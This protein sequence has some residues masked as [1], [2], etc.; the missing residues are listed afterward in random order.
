MDSLTH[1]VVGAVMGD[2]IAGRRL[3]RKAMWLGALFQTIPDFDVI[4]AA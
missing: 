1:I 4:A 2:A 3:G